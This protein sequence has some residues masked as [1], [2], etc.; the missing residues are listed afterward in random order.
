[1]KCLKITIA[2]L[3][4]GPAWPVGA[5][6]PMEYYNSLVAGNDDAGY[7]DG[8]FDDARFNRPCGLAFD[9]TGSRLF[10]ADQNN[11]RIRV[12]Y[13]DEDNRVETAAGKG[14]ASDL[15]GN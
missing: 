11:N 6:T 8:A 13:L 15:D 3:V 5:V 9:E 1:M 2:L 10:V 12:V 14:A 7:R 4:L